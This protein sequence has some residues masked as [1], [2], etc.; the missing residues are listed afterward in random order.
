M[1][2]NNQRQPGYNIRDLCDLVK[3]ELMLSLN[4]HAIATIT[5][6]DPDRQTVEARLAYKQEYEQRD[7]R[8]GKYSTVL[9]DYPLLIDCPAIIMGGGGGALTFPI[10]PGDDCLVFF[11]DRDIDNWFAG[12]PNGAV[13]SSR[14]H[15]SADGIALVGIRSLLKTLKDYDTERVALSYRV[16]GVVQAKMALR[17]KIVLKNVAVDFKTQLDILLVA[18]ETAGTALGSASNFAQVNAAGT[19]LATVALAVQTQMDLLFETEAP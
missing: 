17:E 11:N 1:A 10:V 13:A 6:F 8:S 2:G 18:I 16:G 12:T 9:L 5:S 3:K 4:C 19:A 7:P 14:L 15:S